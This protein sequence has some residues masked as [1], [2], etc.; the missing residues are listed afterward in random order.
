ME[1]EFRNK[2]GDHMV[3]FSNELAN[4]TFNKLNAI[5]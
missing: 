3:S 2:N 4:M 1:L 5:P